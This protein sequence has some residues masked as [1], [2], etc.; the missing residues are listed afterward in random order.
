M[1]GRWR[2]DRPRRRHDHFIIE[3][4]NDR[5]I[6]LNDARRFGSLD[7]VRTSGLQDWP[8]FQGARAGAARPRRARAEAPTGWASPQSSRCC[9][10]S[11][12]SRASAISMSV[13][14]CTAPASIRAGGNIAREA[15]TARPCDPRRSRRSDRGPAGLRFE[16]SPVR[17]GS[18][19]ISPSGLR[20]T[21]GKGS[22]ASAAAPSSAS[23]RGLDLL[24]SQ[25]PAL[26]FVALGPGERDFRCEPAG[27]AVFS[28]S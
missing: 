12:S 9:S 8:P 13:R 23:S 25:G 4:D 2:V 21:I 27:R 10:T 6:A 22:R 5:R 15:G 3:T 26:T 14:R 19:A 24:L 20:C 1:S 7:L 11:A 28:L 17:T 16:I 18:W